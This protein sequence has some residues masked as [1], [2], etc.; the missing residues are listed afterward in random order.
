[1]TRLVAVD[2]PTSDEFVDTLHRIWDAGDAIL[3]LD[4]RLPQAARAALVQRFGAAEVVSPHGIDMMATPR[5]YGPDDAL[6][7][8]TSGT[9]G[10][11]KGVIHTHESLDASTRMVSAALHLSRHDHWVA[12]LP[13]AHI[14]GFG[15]VS[16][17]VATG[18]RLTCL[19][20]ADTEL[21][22]DAVD[23]GATHTAIVPALLPRIEASDWKTILVGGSAIPGDRPSNV[24]ATYG[25][26][27]T[28]GGIAYDSIPLPGVDVRI[29]DGEILVRTPTMCRS[30][31]DGMMRMTDDWLRTGDFGT[32]DDGRLKVDGR[33]DDLI[34][35]GGSKVWPHPVERLLLTHPQ[36]A[37]VVVRGL[38]DDTWGAVVCA[39]IVPRDHAHPPLLD[40]LRTTVRSELSEVA[41]P[42]RII[43]VDEI[44]RTSLG[45]PIVADLPR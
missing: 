19:R 1:M 3:P 38:P 16:R 4:Q 43:I 6:V 30:Y 20:R 29:A 28:C 40:S 11:P 5:P 36:V 34:I 27:E 42:R 33:R 7:I 8:A 45:K 17:A 21:L 41:A 24:V 26:T 32:F 31:V 15:V 39:W 2:L 22:R 23:K 25:L 9:T 13:V 10:L 35:T 14:G 12:C 44:P 37:D 18:A